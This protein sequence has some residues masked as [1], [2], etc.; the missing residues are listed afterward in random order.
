[1]ACAQSST[2][3]R[4]WWH[5]I[6]ISASIRHGCP[7]KC[8]GM[9][10][11]V[12]GVRR[13]SSCFTSRFSVRG[14]TSVN[15]GVAPTWTITLAV[16]GKVM[17]EVMTSSPGPMPRATRP[18]CMAAVQEVTPRARRA[19][20]KRA[21]SCS[22]RWVLG[23]VVSQPERRV[24]TTSASSS[25]PMLGRW[26]GRKLGRTGAPPSMARRS[27][28]VD[29]GLA[30]LDDDGHLAHPELLLPP[31]RVLRVPLDGHVEALV[32]ADPRLPAEHAL[33]LRDVRGVAEDLAG[34]VRHVVQQ[35]LGAARAAHEL[36][37]ERL[38]V[39]ALARA[40][41]EHL[42]RHL[43]HL[44]VE[45]PVE[46]L[47]GVLHVE[48]V[49]LGAAVAVDAERLV[50]E[51]A[52][53]EAG[54]RLLQVLEGAEVVEGADDDGGDLVGRPIRVHEAI[55]ARLGAR[56]GAHGQQRMLLVHERG[57]RGAVD[58]GARDV[59]EAVDGL[60]VLHHGVGHHLCP[61]YVRL[62]EGEVVVDRAGDV[63]LRREVDDTVGLRHE[64]V[65]QLAVPD[66]AV[67]EAAPRVSALD[68]L[69]RQILHAARVGE[70]VDHGEL[71][72]GIAGG[73]VA[74]EVA[75]D[76][77]SAARD[78]NASHLLSSSAGKASSSTSRRRLS[79]PWFMSRSTTDRYGTNAPCSC[80]YTG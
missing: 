58:L 5:A 55:G 53:D 29:N 11:R 4:R 40:D 20:R 76:E 31:A 49:A 15:T 67:P 10:A 28:S 9:M 14:S 50:E 42:A 17:G 51:A 7:A 33:G 1:M 68:Q 65:H 21:N 27:T 60:L 30:S 35:R 47:A 8:T 26:K 63:G 22:K 25:G 6:S 24:S 61:Q 69:L 19:S 37:R 36:Q 77:P 43:P 32:E 41:V 80:G 38:D 79:R 54:N 12:R 23:P 70:G 52:R 16:A 59:D 73:K 74:D 71:V 78:E 57:A 75:S 18:R 44:A 72:V 62:E 56:V 48:P 45:Q 13:A 34:P 66:I 2:T 3:A 64:G 39:R 46:G